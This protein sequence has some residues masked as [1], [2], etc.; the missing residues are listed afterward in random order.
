MEELMEKME[1]MMNEVRSIKSDV[2]GEVECI[3]GLLDTKLKETEV[4]AHETREMVGIHDV[5]INNIQ[6]DQRIN[7]IVIY[8]IQENPNES[9]KDLQA[10]ID[11]LLNNIMDLKIKPDEIN[12][13]FRMG[14]KGGTNQKRPILL[15]MVTYWRKVEILRN[16]VKLKGTK[17]FL[18]QDLTPEEKSER[19]KLLEKVAEIRRNGK[20]AILKGKNIIV[21]GI[22]LAETENTEDSEDDME[23]DQNEELGEQNSERFQKKPTPAGTRTVNRNSSINSIG[24]SQKRELSIS[25]LTKNTERKSREPNMKK[26]RKGIEK[27]TLSLPK[28]SRLDSFIE[29][30][31][32][33]ENNKTLSNEE[34]TRNTTE[35]QENACTEEAQTSKNKKDE[36]SDNNKPED[37]NETEEE[38]Q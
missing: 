17:I 1:G 15:K 9:W 7:N 21:E 22:L 20:H 12:Q 11:W 31:K 14:K 2:K 29:Y 24:T 28:Q 37:K 34:H 30:G 23:V 38:N 36:T 32:E 4:Y 33:L 5:K 26:P 19:K 10:H 18:A 13:F 8:G 16:T 35:S 6:K 3:R 25:P 27:R